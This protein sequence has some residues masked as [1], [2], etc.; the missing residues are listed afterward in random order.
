MVLEVAMAPG[1]QQPV[2]SALFFIGAKGQITAGIARDLE[3]ALAPGFSLQS[4]NSTACNFHFLLSD[5]NSPG[6]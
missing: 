2:A 3:P 6:I 5:G 4:A 1:K